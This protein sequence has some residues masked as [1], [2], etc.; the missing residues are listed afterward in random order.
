[1]NDT[2]LTAINAARAIRSM[3]DGSKITPALAHTLLV[4]ATYY[5]NIFPS[6]ETLARD[7]SVSRRQ[8]NRRLRPLE[9]AR[10]IF[11]SRREGSSTVYRLNLGAIRKGRGVTLVPPEDQTNDT[12][13][14]GVDFE[15]EWF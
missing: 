8:V 6:Q 3:P 9:D 7:M 1:M 14:E 10:L 4:L 13:T 2:T 11:R 15:D 5:P 12:L